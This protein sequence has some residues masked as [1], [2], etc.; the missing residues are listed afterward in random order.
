M[1]SKVRVI[2]VTV[3]TVLAATSAFSFIGQNS[4]FAQDT[5]EQTPQ[6]QAL[7]IIHRIL[8]DNSDGNSKGWNPD[9]S[10]RIFTIYDSAYNPAT[11]VVVVNTKQANFVICQ[12]DYWYNGAFEVY[13]N[14]APSNGGILNYAIINTEVSLSAATAA[15]ASEEV[16]QEAQQR[17]LSAERVPPGQGGGQGGGQQQGGGGVQ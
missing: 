8:Q 4:S 17:E 5:P 13:C 7:S 12:V 6:P 2:P 1:K 10:R 15:T 11:S 3:L 16:Q 14:V 9:G